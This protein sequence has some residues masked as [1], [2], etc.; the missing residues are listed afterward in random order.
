MALNDIWI[1]LM[2]IWASHGVL[3][4]KTSYLKLHFEL[5]TERLIFWWNPRG[6]FWTK[7]NEK[8]INL[9]EIK[10]RRNLCPFFSSLFCIFLYFLWSFC[11]Q[12][13]HPVHGS[14]ELCPTAGC[15][16]TLEAPHIP[17][18]TAMIL[19]MPMDVPPSSQ[20]PKCQPSAGWGD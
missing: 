10:L 20:L 12:Q 15:S 7:L 1:A 2:R 17:C 13:S 6:C 3:N 16:C 8:E 18:P 11:K 4:V 5:K 19:E 14:S 9:E